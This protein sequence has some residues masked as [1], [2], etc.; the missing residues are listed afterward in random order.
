MAQARNRDERLVFLNVKDGEADKYALMGNGFTDLTTS[1]NPTS[2]SKQYVHQK[3]ASGSVSGYAPSTSFTGEV[4]DSDDAAEYIL[5]IADHWRTDEKAH[6]DIVI[7]DTW[8]KGKTAD[9][10]KARKQDIVISIDNPGS[11]SAGSVLGL[12]GTLQHSG[13]PID[14][15]FNIKTLAFTPD[16]S[17]TSTTE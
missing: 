2:E 11:G 7:V 15:E 17:T 3:V 8:K 14:G 16:T 6:T 10:F 4:F 5:D 1:G 12:T 9:S 13:E